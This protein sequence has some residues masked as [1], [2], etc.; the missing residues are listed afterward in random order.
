MFPFYEHICIFD[1]NEKFPENMTQ[2]K[3]G[4]E[5]LEEEEY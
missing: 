5:M 1:M 4:K 2:S 3:K